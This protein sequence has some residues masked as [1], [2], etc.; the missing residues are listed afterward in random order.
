[1]NGPTASHCAAELLDLKQDMS[2][3]GQIMCGQRCTLN[4]NRDG[5]TA[6][7]VRTRVINHCF[8]KLAG[9]RN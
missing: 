1:M 4:P 6:T 5:S 9:E 7:H 3:I 8:T 2:W